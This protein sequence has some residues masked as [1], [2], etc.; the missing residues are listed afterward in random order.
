MWITAE[1]S[2]CFDDII[3]GMELSPTPP[4]APVRLGARIDPDEFTIG[5][6]EAAELYARAGHPRTIRRI[7]KYC[8]RGDLVCCKV[9]TAFGEKYMITRSSIDKHIGQIEDAL[10]ASGRAPA[11]PGAPMNVSEIASVFE[12]DQTAPI[13]ARTRPDA[14]SD[15]EQK[16]ENSITADAASE[17][18]STPPGDAQARPDAP[19]IYQER[20]LA[21]LEKE[22]EFLREQNTVLLERVKETNILTQGLQKMLSP[23]LGRPSE[24]ASPK[25]STENF[26][27]HE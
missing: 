17:L 3:S 11:R 21:H 18:R 4:D 15:A 19:Q 12:H 22:N 27:T 25:D 10:A 16:L 2:E 7:Q 20:Y 8:A 9:E 24:P 6:D 13:G 1:A 14:P 5:V 23:L 26:S